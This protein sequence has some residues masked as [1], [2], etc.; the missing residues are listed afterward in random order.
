MLSRCCA[1]T[2]KWA[3]IRQPTEG[4]E[5]TCRWCAGYLKYERIGTSQHFGWMAHDKL[6]D[7]INRESSPEATARRAARMREILG[8]EPDLSVKKDDV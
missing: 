2:L 6:T 8:H 7:F 3:N 4:L 1:D 5:L